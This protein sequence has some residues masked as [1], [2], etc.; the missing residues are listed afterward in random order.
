MI[1]SAPWR[2]SCSAA[3]ISARNSTTPCGCWLPPTRRNS[4]PWTLPADSISRAPD[5]TR[6]LDKL[7]RR[8]FIDR[9]RPAAN[10]RIVCVGI[11][12]TGLA[13]LR[14]LRQPLRDCHERQLG[15]LSRKELDGLNVLL[16]SA[17]LPHEDASSDWR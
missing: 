2:R 3:T 12:E 16:R 14:E 15:H 1:A 17:R 10:R 7:E 11:T 9:D 5:I 13:L 4:A 8:G 6:L